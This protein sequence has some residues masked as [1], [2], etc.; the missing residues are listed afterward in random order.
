MDHTPSSPKKLKYW[1]DIVSCDFHFHLLIKFMFHSS[2]LYFR[3][4]S[5][6]I[7]VILCSQMRDDAYIFIYIHVCIVLLFNQSKC[8]F[9][10]KDYSLLLHHPNL[11]ALTKSFIHIVHACESTGLK[12]ANNEKLSTDRVPMIK[13]LLMKIKACG[14]KSSCQC[15]KLITHYKRLH[16]L[17]LDFYHTL[18]HQY[19]LMYDFNML[20]IMC[21]FHNFKT[22]RLEWSKTQWKITPF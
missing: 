21:S 15:R 13:H 4:I 7:L 19:K 17:M 10:L 20:K 9:I 3:M 5:K 22:L 2:N 1:A 16:V 11:A 6:H 8:L 14:M 18:I 12:R